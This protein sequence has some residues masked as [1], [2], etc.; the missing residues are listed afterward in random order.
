M[1]KQL[2]VGALALAFCVSSC[3]NNDN[4]TP[5]PTP[6]KG[7]FDATM[8]ISTT[9]VNPDGTSGKCYV[10]AI[11]DTTAMT[12]DNSR[13]IPGG[14]GNPFTVQGKNIYIFPDYMGTS[15]AELTRYQLD[16]NH[17]FVKQ[18]TLALPANSATSQVLEVNDSIA[19]VSCQNLGKLLVFNFNK[20]QMRGEIDLN[21]YAQDGLRVGPSCMVQRDGKVFVALSQFDANWMPHKNSVEFALIDA[22]THKAE[23]LIKN[24]SI[25]MSFPT[26]PI[27]NGTLFVDEKGDIYFSCLGS[28]GFIPE[29]HAGFGRIKKGETEIDAT[30]KIRLDETNIAGLDKKGDYVA[31]MQYAGNGKAYTYISVSALDPKALANPYSAIIACPVEVDLYNRTLTLIKDLPISNPHSIAIG[32]YKDLVVYGCGNATST[33][34]YYFNTTTRKAWGPVIKTVGNPSSIFFTKD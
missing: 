25:G 21:S 4:P 28:F 23:K 13:A 33:G 3:D 14:F 12:I 26:R 9:V 19:Y 8:L 5:N 32:K 7:A 16:K 22:K 34:F 10:Q 18:G 6:Q 2:L 20:M 11:N 17:Q 1:K 27:T 24:E 15:K 31:A 29:F 30:Y